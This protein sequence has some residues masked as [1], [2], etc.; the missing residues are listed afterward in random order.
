MKYTYIFADRLLAFH[1]DGNEIDE[2]QRIF[3]CWNDPEFLHDF[4][5]ENEADLKSG[6]FGDISIVTAA[7]RT[8]DEARRFENKIRELST[9]PN[10][11]LDQLFKPLSVNGERVFERSKAYGTRN[12]SWLRIYALKI[13]PE[14]YIV[15][16]GAIKLTQRMDAQE[17]TRIELRKLER[18]RDFLRELGITDIEGFKEIDL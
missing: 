1:Y 5:V 11:S 2:F 13:Q 12:D 6:F 4:F 9:D 15:T 3:D 8:R 18:C 14:C 17:H 16:G 10:K 7:S